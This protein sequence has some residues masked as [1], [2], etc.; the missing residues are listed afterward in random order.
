[1]SSLPAART[2]VTGATGFIGGHLCRALAQRGERVE[3]WARPGSG[4]GGLGAVAGVELHSV[5]VC[6]RDAVA[7]AISARPPRRVLH[8]AGVRIIGNS[9]ANLRRM[10]DTNVRGILH[11]LEALPASARVV[12][13]G[14]AEEY[15]RGPVPFSESQPADPQTAYAVTRLAATQSV[16]ALARPGTC[17]ARLSVV[18]GPRQRGEMFIPS[19]LAACAARRTFAMSLGE[20]TRDFLY[21][22]DAVRGLIALSGAESAGGIVNVASGVEVTVRHVAEEAARLTGAGADLRIGAI[23]SRAG[24][25]S[26]YVC[27]IERMRALTG[28]Y[29]EIPLRDG[30]VRTLGWWRSQAAD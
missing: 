28:W 14:S 20:Q 5:D 13:V 17:V 24:E 29:P 18:Y 26:R 22:D 25:A 4:D 23:P 2:L 19:L 21:V 7:A 10:F 30:L 9:A 1:V 15:G 12:Y 27:S 11:V 8:L 16:L 3:A 6:D